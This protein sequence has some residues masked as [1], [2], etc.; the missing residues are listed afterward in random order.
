MAPVSRLGGRQPAGHAP[1]RHRHARPAHGPHQPEHQ[2][3]DPPRQDRPD[4][5]HRLAGGGGAS[6]DR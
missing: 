1:A 2:A 3:H 6:G 5:Q 4:P